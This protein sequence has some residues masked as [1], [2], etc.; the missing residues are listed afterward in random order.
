MTLFFFKLYKSP[1]VYWGKRD[2]AVPDKKQNVRIK[3]C[4]GKRGLNIPLGNPG[5]KD[6]KGKRGDMKISGSIDGYR[7]EKRNLAP[8]KGADKFISINDT[9]RKAISKSGGDM[10]SVTLY[11]ESFIEKI[12]KNK[13]L[14]V[15]KDA[16]GN[17]YI[18]EPS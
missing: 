5:T 1:V 18:Q 4:T 7:I 15:F 16:G 3:V 12:D 6:I 8:I 2:Y 17:A 9:I 10:V 11:L 14:E 13:I